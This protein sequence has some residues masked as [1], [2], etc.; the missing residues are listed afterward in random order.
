MNARY[1]LA[2]YFFSEDTA[3]ANLYN[4]EVAIDHLYA[5]NADVPMKTALIKYLSGE[6]PSF[7]S[8]LLDELTA[9]Y[10]ELSEYG[11]WEFPL[12]PKFIYRFLV[13]KVEV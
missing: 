6:Q 5:N 3:T 4:V 13:K 10:G 9:G 1:N 11:E 12:P 7:S 2:E 8:D